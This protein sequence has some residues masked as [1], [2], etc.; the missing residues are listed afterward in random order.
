MKRKTIVVT[1][2]A[3]GLTLSTAAGHAARFGDE[4]DTSWLYR[5]AASNIESPAKAPSTATL[6]AV[7]HGDE[8]DTSW[9]YTP[10]AAKYGASASGGTS[11]PSVERR[12]ASVRWGDENDTSWLPRAAPRS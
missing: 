6:P 1:L 8:N 5:P 10:P 12:K 2:F 9:L 3:T 7:R 4:N 11:M